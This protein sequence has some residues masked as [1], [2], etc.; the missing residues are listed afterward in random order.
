MKTLREQ[1]KE[2]SNN[3]DY[4]ELH[5]TLV[6]TTNRVWVYK[7]GTIDVQTSGTIPNPEGECP[8]LILDSHMYDEFGT[9]YFEGWGHFDEE[10]QDVFITD[11]KRRLTR[12]EAVKECIEDGDWHEWIEQIEELIYRDLEEEEEEEYQDYLESPFD[13]R[14]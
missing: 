5:K 1:V 12:E 2:I 6:F 13:P 7:D 9:D 3:I 10:D 11:D 14:D 4:T 8:V